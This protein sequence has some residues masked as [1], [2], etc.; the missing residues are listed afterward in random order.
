MK[1]QT[2]RHLALLTVM[3]FGITAF[4]LYVK[5]QFAPSP[6]AHAATTSFAGV[7]WADARDNF[8]TG[9]VIVPK[10][11]VISSILERFAAS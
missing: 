2:V 5:P 9:W 8:N 6:L 1:A 11:V 4:T 7:N 3:L 10:S